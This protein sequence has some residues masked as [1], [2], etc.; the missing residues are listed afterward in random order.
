MHRI[1]EGLEWAEP[2]R[3]PYGKTPKTPRGAKGAGLRFERQVASGI[4]GA[5]TGRWFVFRDA[6]GTGYCSPD[7]ILATAQGLIVLECKLSDTPHAFSQIE[8]LYKPVLQMVFRRPVAGIV[9]AKHLR[10]HTDTA[11]VVEDLRS[12]LKFLRD[13][14]GSVP[15]LHWMGRSVAHLRL[16]A[17]SRSDFSPSA[18]SSQALA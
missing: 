3:N 13:R 8:R 14:P 4:T 1:I 16:D 6:N 11:L 5:R 17:Q 9:V 12:A 18:A 15:I 7:I 10:A 2:A